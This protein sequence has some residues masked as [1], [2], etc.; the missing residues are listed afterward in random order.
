M[1]IYGRN[2]RQ[3]R[4]CRRNF[5][6][7]LL[8]HKSGPL[9]KQLQ[10]IC[11]SFFTAPKPNLEQI[12]TYLRLKPF[13]LK[14]EIG[15]QLVCATH[16]LEPV[17]HQRKCTIYPM[18]YQVQIYNNQPGPTSLAD[19]L[20]HPFVETINQNV[21]KEHKCNP[22]SRKA[23]IIPRFFDILGDTASSSKP[24]LQL[25]VIRYLVLNPVFLGYFR[26]KHGNPT[27]V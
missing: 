27:Y 3:I 25:L 4:Y 7:N 20:D 2:P 26:Q 10:H 12:L 14:S 13:S 1:L 17:K 9:K 22:Y 8:H 5:A 18:L 16:E 21:N 23:T 24:D 15:Q 19:R 6:T 11:Y